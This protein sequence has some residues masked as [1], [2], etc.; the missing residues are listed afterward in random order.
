M[1]TD[2]FQFEEFDEFYHEAQKREEIDQLSS[3]E[4]EIDTEETKAFWE[5]QHQLLQEALSRRSST[6]VRIKRDTEEA[7]KKMESC[8]SICDCLKECRRNCALRYVTDRLRD[9]GYNS[10]LCKSKWRR[11][12]EIP[13]GEHYF[14]DVVVESKNPKKDPIRVVVEPNFRA[15]F[16]MAR[17]NAEYNTLVR[18]LPEI[19]VGK[20]E[21]LRHVIKIVCGA[22]K[23]CMKDN[24]MHMAPWRKHKYMLSKWLGTCE[25]V[26]PGA[27]T[28]AM[29]LER[30]ASGSPASRPRASMLTFDL[31]CTAVKVM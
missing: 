8:G 4:E 26:T 6:E 23:K 29:V 16:E 9:A 3:D 12:P 5:S 7:I 27:S 30:S 18:K 22:A 21:G 13:S 24:K 19:F 28:T 11:S 2:F 31:R 17:A 10:A 1:T 14:A 15:E 25:R 20:S